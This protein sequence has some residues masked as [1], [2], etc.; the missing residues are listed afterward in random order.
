M[1]DERPTLFDAPITL[2]LPVLPYGG[3][4]GWSGSEA[5]HDRAEHDDSTGVTSHRQATVLT[6]LRTAGVDGLTWTELAYMN[7]WH[8]GTASGALSVLHKAG[9][10]A[11][12]TVRRDGSSVYVAN[13][14][15]ADRPTAEH[16]PNVSARLLRLVLEELQADLSAG[17]VELARARV[18][19]TLSALN[20]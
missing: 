1:T 18:G 3:S 10:I 7:G 11:R 9:K 15:V 13:E 4:S 6:A 19:A 17:R 12:L 20:E 2:D 14:F 16:R 8:H 5:S